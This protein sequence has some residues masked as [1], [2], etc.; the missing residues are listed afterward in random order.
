MQEHDSWTIIIIHNV[1]YS[2][3]CVMG[4]DGGMRGGETLKGYIK[5]NSVFLNSSNIHN[6]IFIGLGNSVNKRFR[7]RYR[8]WLRIGRIELIL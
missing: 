3:L 4:G 6:L 2:Y 7:E 5:L 1:K 8:I